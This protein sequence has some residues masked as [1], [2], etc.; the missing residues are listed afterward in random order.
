MMLNEVRTVKDT[1]T[2]VREETRRMNFMGASK[3]YMTPKPD[4]LTLYTLINLPTHEDTIQDEDERM[5]DD[6]WKVSR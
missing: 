5:N 3:Y 6:S 1:D 4:R 2:I